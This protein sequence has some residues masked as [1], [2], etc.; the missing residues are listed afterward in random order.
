MIDPTGN[1]LL[2]ANQNSNNI[3]VFKI[4]AD[5]GLL[6]ETG[7]EVAVQRPVCLKMLEIH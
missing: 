3:V 1:Y 6:H 5:T 4:D 2:V 7:V